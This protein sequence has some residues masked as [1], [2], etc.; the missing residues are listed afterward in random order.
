MR[1][2]HIAFNIPDPVAAADWYTKCLGMRV[3]SRFGPPSHTHF[4]AEA[5]G[6]TMIEIYC[7]TK[8]AVP[9]Y[10]A[11]DPLV[12][13]LAFAVDDVHAMRDRLLKA[14]AVAVGDVAISDNGDHLAMLRD[15]W[16][17]PIQLVKRA[18][19]MG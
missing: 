13:H 5:G 8:V 4:L 16:G 1:I 17:F 19:P 6:Q 12:L 18:A 7:N 11:L 15:P 3:V 10:G 9:D 2:E 14:G